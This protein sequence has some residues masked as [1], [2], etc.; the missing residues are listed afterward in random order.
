MGVSDRV[1]LGTTEEIKVTSGNNT[2][3]IIARIDTGASKSSIDKALAKELG[4]GPVIETKVVKSAHGS[5]ERPIVN[6]NITLCGKTITEKFTVV[7]R[8]H[9][10]YKALIGRN[11]L[12]KGFIID[13]NKQC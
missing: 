3:I 4:L 10:K 8:S 12:E 7:D 6:V 11:I 1:I 2:K 9:M 5:R 13:P